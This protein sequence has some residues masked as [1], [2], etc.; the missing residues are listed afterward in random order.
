MPR[1]LV[2]LEVLWRP[3]QPSLGEAVLEDTVRPYPVTIA[4]DSPVGPRGSGPPLASATSLSSL[5]S[6]PSCG[7]GYLPPCLILPLQLILP[8]PTG[9]C[10][11]LL[12]PKALMV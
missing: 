7:M 12:A 8:N 10:H 3:G 9:G 11:C 5:F 2:G 1:C 6:C 4:C